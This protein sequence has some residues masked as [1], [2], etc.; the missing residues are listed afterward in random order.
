MDLNVWGNL[1]IASCFPI[2]FGNWNNGTTD[3]VFAENFN[4]SRS[5]SNVNIG[6]RSST[7]SPS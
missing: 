2:V 7:I 5:N 6:F 1:L 4:N 3:G